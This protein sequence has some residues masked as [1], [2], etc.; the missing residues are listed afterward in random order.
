MPTNCGTLRNLVG[1]I[2][3]AIAIAITLLAPAGYFLVGYVDQ[4]NLVDLKT[5]IASGRLAKYIYSHEKLWQYQRVRLTELLE[6]IDTPDAI[7]GMRVLD[8][9]SAVVLEEGSDPAKPH[10]TRTHPIIVRGA[11]IG[12]TEIVS[13]LRPL[14]AETA[15]VGLLS[16]VLGF[17]AYFAVRAFPLRVLDRTIGALREANR[18]TGD[19][20]QLLDA[21]LNNMSQ[22]LCMFDTSQCLIVSNRRFAVMFGIDEGCITPGMT[23]REV[24]RVGIRGERLTE[25]DAEFAIAAQSRLIADRKPDSLAWDLADGRTISICHEP[26]SDGG[27]VSTYLDV[28]DQRR[29]EARIAFMARHDALTSLPNRRLFREYMQ[30]AL[31]HDKGAGGFA[32]LS[33]DFDR[34]KQVNDTLGHPIGDK[35]L[36]TATERLRA[37]LRHSDRIARLGG[38]EFAVLQESVDQPGAASALARRLIAAMAVP[39]EIDGHHVVVG[40]SV[41]ISLAP[42]HGL[43]PDQLLRN[44]DMALYRAK[45]DGR[46][47]Y[48]FFEPE[49]DAREQARRTLELDLRRSL[50]NN[51]FVLF[52]QPLVRVDTLDVCGFE[53]LLRWPHPQRG[54][55]AATEFV[56]LAEEIGLIVPLGEWVLRQACKEAASWPDHIKVAVNL[57]PL[58]FRNRALAQT[59]VSA[60]AHAGLAPE[61]LELEITE[62]VLIEDSESSLATMHQLRNLGVRIVMD[63]FGTGYS[64]LSYLRRFPFDKIKIDRSFIADLTTGNHSLAIVRAVTGLAGS[65][66][67]PTTAE[68]VETTEQLRRLKL[69]GCTEAQGF[70]F[71]RPAA[72][73]SVAA[74]LERP[75][76]TE[77]A[78]A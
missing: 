4:I 74:L 15:I 28:S 61:R 56:A 21:A 3:L 26:M 30:G 47:V 27:W 33:I 41:G 31:G 18:R 77:I 69:E 63:D 25:G 20:N 23:H 60:L 17:A 1:G 43:D 37:C 76:P 55:I 5:R 64:S 24:M 32:L 8:A 16:A 66:G 10:L 70:L 13:S 7:I 67:I 44:A 19:A 35:L 39:Y 48:R 73:D 78:A 59:V 14:L 65:L 40:A 38:D 49:M 9:K 72:A 62:S 52:Y 58:Q 57:S 50:A 45:T 6:E 2:G 53:V 54:M 11:P 71:G 34:F 22:G 46:G 68:G 29:A 75:Y 42:A 12:R 36:I 51:E